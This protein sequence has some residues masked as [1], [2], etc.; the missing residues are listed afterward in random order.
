MDT[1]QYDFLC[2]LEWKCF[3]STQGFCRK[4][5]K[6]RFTGDFAAKITIYGKSLCIIFSP[7]HWSALFIDR[8]CMIIAHAQILHNCAIAIRILREKI[9]LWDRPIGHI[10]ISQTQC[11]ESSHTQVDFSVLIKILIWRGTLKNKSFFVHSHK[12]HKT[13]IKNRWQTARLVIL[14]I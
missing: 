2:K 10:N 3:L 11:C 1:H 9:I 14:C 8:L 5:K 6:L 4:S 13:I 12:K 7:S